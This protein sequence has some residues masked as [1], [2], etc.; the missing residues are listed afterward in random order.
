MR[1]IGAV[2]PQLNLQGQSRVSVSNRSTYMSLSVMSSVP[3]DTVST[4]KFNLT[5]IP[6]ARTYKVADDQ[7][8]FYIDWGIRDWG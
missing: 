8:R 6:E 1:A 3:E 7:G 4:F 2:A 5:Q